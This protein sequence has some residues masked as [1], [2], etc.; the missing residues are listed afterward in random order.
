MQPKLQFSC[1]Q[2]WENM[3]ISMLGKHCA[4]CDKEVVDF[5]GGTKLDLIAYLQANQGRSVCGRVRP[6]Q[7][8]HYQEL[9]E[10][11]IQRS[12][13]FNR[14]SNLAYYLLAV[15]GLSM[16]ACSQPKVDYTEDPVGVKDRTTDT[17]SKSVATIPD[18]VPVAPPEPQ[19]TE[20]FEEEYM[21]FV[22]DVA[23]ES[24]PFAHSIPLM[25]FPEVMPE[26]PGGSDSLLVFLQKQVVYPEWEVTKGIQGRVMVKFTVLDDGTVIDPFIVSRVQGA[27]NFDSEVLRVMALMPKWIPG[28]TDGKPV[29]STFVL[30]FKFTL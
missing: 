29:N 3:R 18:E 12:L 17:T 21:P 16:Q 14:S 2:P 22:G 26:F 19:G 25:V 13:R 27:R 1:S 28:T 15:T 24:G 11:T 5:I 6:D 7:V 10:V 8:D 4:H 9:I 23:L 30:P 20:R